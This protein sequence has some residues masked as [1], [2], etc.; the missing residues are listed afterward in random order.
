MLSPHSPVSPIPLAI[1]PPS[2]NVAQAESLNSAISPASPILSTDD[3]N[4][5]S[6]Q[7]TAKTATKM[8][9]MLSKARNHAESEQ[10]LATLSNRAS[11]LS[12]Q[13]KEARTKLEQV[14]ERKKLWHYLS[15]KSARDSLLQECI[16]YEKAAS[17][18]KAQTML[19]CHVLECLKEARKGLNDTIEQLR[20]LQEE[21][22]KEAAVQANG[23]EIS[24]DILPPYTPPIPDLVLGESQHFDSDLSEQD[25][26]DP[27]DRTR[28]VSN[29][30]SIAGSIHSLAEAGLEVPA[31]VHRGS[32]S[33]AVLA[34]LQRPL[35]V[36][37]A[38]MRRRLRQWSLARAASKRT[39]ALRDSMR[40]VGEAASVED[41]KKELAQLTARK[42]SLKQLLN[43]QVSSGSLSPEQNTKLE[44]LSAAEDKVAKLQ[45][46]ELAS[47]EKLA[48]TKRKL[49]RLRFEDAKVAAELEQQNAILEI[50]ENEATG[51]KTGAQRLAML[52]QEKVDRVLEELDV[53]NQEMHIF[54]QAQNQMRN[55]NRC[56]ETQLADERAS[57]ADLYKRHSR[58]EL[59]AEALAKYY[60]EA[61][62]SPQQLLPLEEVLQGALPA[63]T[64][65]P[66]SRSG[67]KLSTH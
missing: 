14:Q 56:L 11:V 45:A 13:V 22:V 37:A 36:Q 50:F 30:G 53:A 7:T 18:A 55:R 15:S 34:A 24:P 65:L 2:E 33:Q 27:F 5:L 41:A 20:L 31:E 66:P 16:G 6:L 21:D 46:Q 61:L 60:L 1:V 48:E 42:E 63:L 26:I 62:P 29:A 57:Y 19:P 40:N 23:A 4:R 49:H 44:E 35:A 12:E 8:K 47:R 51:R 39:E 3:P 67:S 25:R 9:R 43:A 28:S 58:T 32:D 59:E 54:Q 38:E 10:E 64:P 52:A 17:L